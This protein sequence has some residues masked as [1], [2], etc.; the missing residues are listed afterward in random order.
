MHGIEQTSQ[1]HLLN[2]KCNTQKVEFY[3]MKY[4]R[5]KINNAGETIMSSK[6]ENEVQAAIEIVNDWRTLHLIVLD[7]LQQ[8][9]TNLIK[10]K[11]INIALVSR[12]LKRL[13]SIKYKLDLNPDMRLGGMQD[14]G[15]LRVV[16]LD[17]SSLFFAYDILK[18]TIPESFS[19]EKAV[20]YINPPKESGYR[21]FHFVYK[22]KSDNNDVDGMKVELQIRTKLQHSWAMAVETAGLIT[23]TPLKSSLG[24]DDWLEFFRIVSSLFA[25]KEKQPILLN[26]QK[27]GYSLDDLMRLFYESNRKHNY[28]DTLKALRVSIDHAEKEKYKDGYYILDI[29]FES[30]RVNVMAYAKKDEDKASIVYSELEKS[31][32]ETTNSVVLVSV[33]KM[34]ELREAYPSYFLDTSDFINAIDQMMENC[35]IRGLVSL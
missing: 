29:N 24:S 7:A 35:I 19:L 9:I 11:N 15:G 27:Q 8:E 12:R 31:A 22:Y 30:K 2:T 21:G 16:L 6:D 14:I 33:P 17:T 18:S 32:K 4:S 13:S 10:Q 34:K 3:C 23:R 20:D 26:H 28:G 1:Q 5:N 25:I